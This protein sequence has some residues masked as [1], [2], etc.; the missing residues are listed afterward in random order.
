VLPLPALEVPATLQGSLMARLDRLPGAKVVA[1]VGAVI[2]REFAYA[3]LA[4]VADLPQPELDA[5]LR[6]LEEG[7]LVV[8][9]GE[10]PTATYGFKH[11]LVRD[12]AYESLLRS[13]RQ[14]LHRRLV[15]AI[16][17]EFP[18]LGDGQPELLAHHCAGA[19][20]SEKAIGYWR[21]A[22]EQ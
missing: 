16:E 8:R 11:A 17:G 3:F 1:Q 22:G 2:G 7:D 5:A 18:Q 19:G 21:K 14:V 6:A 10:P 9:R 20:L 4:P 13:R 12:A 15:A